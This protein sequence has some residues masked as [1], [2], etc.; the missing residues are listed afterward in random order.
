MTCEEVARLIESGIPG[1]QATVKD[2]TGTGDHFSAVVVAK[3]FDDKS[4]LKTHRFPDIREKLRDAMNGKY[5]KCLKKLPSFAEQFVMH[6][7]NQTFKN[8]VDGV[9]E[10]LFLRETSCAVSSF[11]VADCVFPTVREIQDYA[12]RNPGTV[13]EDAVV[14]AQRRALKE[15]LNKV[16]SA[17]ARIQNIEAELKKQPEPPRDTSTLGGVPWK[18]AL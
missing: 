4:P 11:L 13:E 15:W 9:N 6:W 18:Q 7:K 8:D 16:E 12:Q 17:V 5:E 3:A 10:K 14:K 2:L 1:A